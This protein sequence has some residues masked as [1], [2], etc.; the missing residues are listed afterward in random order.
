MEQYNKELKKLQENLQNLLKRPSAT[1]GELSTGIEKDIQQTTEDI[2]KCEES[3]KRLKGVIAESE[4]ELEKVGA[5]LAQC[6]IKM[7]YAIANLKKLKKSLNVQLL[8]LCN[9]KEKLANSSKKLSENVFLNSSQHREYESVI[10]K[11]KCMVER[12]ENNIQLL[13]NELETA[14]STIESS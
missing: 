3:L 13:E 9:D 5:C 14:E 2:D 1:G 10:E 12:L 7:D 8:M 4:K 11:C 6:K